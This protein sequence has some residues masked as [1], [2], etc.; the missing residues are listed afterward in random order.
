MD[1]GILTF[2]NARELAGMLKWDFFKLLGKKEINRKYDMEEV[3]RD[4]E[5]L[6]TL[7]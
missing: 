7:D 3:N 4:L 2:G 1:Q 6:E 5:T